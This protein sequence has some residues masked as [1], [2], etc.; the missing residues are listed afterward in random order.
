MI[1]AILRAQWLSMHFGWGRRGL[2]MVAGLVWYGVW[3]F[4]AFA[5]G[6]TV[7]EAGR[8]RLDLYLPLGLL[9]VCAYWQVMPVLSASMGSALDLKKLR[10]YPVPHGK[11]FA[12]EVL[13][14]LT[15][16]AEM[17]MVVAAGAIGLTRND[18]A[19]GA[20]AVA[21]V[22]IVLPL[23]AAFNLLLSSGMRS[24]LERLFSRRKI[25]EVMALLLAMLW[26]APR[27]LVH[28]GYGKGVLER[29]GGSMRSVALPWTAAARAAVGEQVAGAVASLA[30]WTL[31]AAWFGRWQFERSL[32]HDATA[33][34]ATPS[35]GSGARVA[36][37]DRLYRLPSL[38]WRDPL[39]AIVEKELRSLARTPR[40]RT[41]FLMG[42]T[43]GLAVWL[44]VAVNR[45][46]PAD[47]WFLTVV[48]VYALT[49]LGQVSY[50]NCFGF[51][52]SATAFYF[53]APVGFARVLVA[54]NIA[55]LAYLYLEVLLVIGV[56]TALGLAAGWR[57]AVET[58]AVT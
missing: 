5:A 9:G 4:V 36:V 14:R 29:A 58:L 18:E 23:F 10:V 1:R 26:V 21:R 20:A 32:R 53:A 51:D 34:Q 11:L 17:L 47:S 28:F 42:F 40:F 19:G 12:I 55:A 13:L 7:A 43:F 39:A 25:R 33:A 56:T 24:L 16:G 54:K 27:L 30:A 49:L 31:A 38:L 15:T 22:A 50:W 41:V 44:P 2:S 3:A 37:M 35:Q 52:R 45:K 46:E 6:V 8:A 57:P 48:A